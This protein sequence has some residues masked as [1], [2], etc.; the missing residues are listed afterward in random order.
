MSAPDGVVPDDVSTNDESIR[1]VKNE[2]AA[3][4]EIW[5]GDTLAGV[6]QYRDS[7][8]HVNFTHTEVEP[9]FE[10]KGLAGQLARYALDDVVDQG[11]LI[12]TTCPYMT[13]YVRRHPEYLDHV[14]G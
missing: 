10:G 12:V 3:Q 2:S 6:A 8:D 13:V 11:K 14:R 7:P 5:V 1:F 4:Y 9:E